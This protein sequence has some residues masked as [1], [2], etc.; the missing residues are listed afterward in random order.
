[1]KNLF[2]GDKENNKIAEYAELLYDQA[3]IAEGGALKDPVKFSQRLS[4][5][6]VFEG[7]NINPA[8]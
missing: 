5:L 4:D 8:K 7:Q 6:M 1:M 2:E 3:I